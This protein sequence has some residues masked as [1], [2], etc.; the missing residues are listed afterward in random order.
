MKA[1]ME[2]LAYD[3][4]EDICVKEVCKAAEVAQGTF[5]NYFP[6]KIEVIA[7]YLRLSTMRM[8]WKAKKYAQPG[9]YLVL[10][11]AIFD[12]IAEEWNTDH[13]VY[14]STFCFSQQTDRPKN[15]SIPKLKKAAFS[16]CDGIEDVPPY[17]CRSVQDWIYKALDN[18]ELPAGVN[19]DDVVVALMAII[20]G[21]LLATRFGNNVDKRGYY[22]NT[23][24]EGFWKGLGVRRRKNEL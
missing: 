9:K 3:R 4:F 21:T 23:S 16:A 8:A 6:E 15:V 22:Y 14:Y 2:R 11:D 17:D 18:G 20:G 5:F 1:F 7:Y 13:I 12:Q 10:V 24:S 19:A